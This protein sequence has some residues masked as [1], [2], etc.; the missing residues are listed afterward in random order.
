MTM[1]KR[2]SAFIAMFCCIFSALSLPG[3]FQPAFAGSPLNTL[4]GSW[5]GSGSFQLSDGRQERIKCNAYYTGGGSQLRMVVRCQGGE[6]KIEIRSRLSHNAGR[7][8]G[9]WEERTYHAEG[10]ASGSVSGQS[11]NL[12]IKG[13]VSASMRVSF[14]RSRQTISVSVSGG[15]LTS[16]N[17][18]LSRR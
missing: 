13:G 7:L 1:Q 8:S 18:T 16:V 14:S 12:S 15:Q 6:N 9:T 3:S 10:T 5:G 2:Q 17:I 11:L 4:M